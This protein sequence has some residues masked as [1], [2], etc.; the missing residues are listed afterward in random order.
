MTPQPYRE[1]IRYEYDLTPLDFVHD[2]GGHMG[3]FADAIFNRYGCFVHVWE[4]ISSYYAICMERFKEND[5]ITV[6]NCGVGAATTKAIFRVKGNMSGAWA[7]DGELENVE[8]IDVSRILPAALIKI[9]IEG[10]EYAVL[11]RLLE[12]GDITR[13]KN[14]QIQWHEFPD[15]KEELTARRDYIIHELRKTHELTFDYGWVWQ[16]WRIK[17]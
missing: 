12:T 3:D 16:N 1:D 4:P 5:K 9:N 13:F 17:K 14:C 7:D 8:M 10:G 6:H 2:C 15:R 11:E